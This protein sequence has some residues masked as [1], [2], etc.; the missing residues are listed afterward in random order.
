MKDGYVG[1]VL[2]IW[3][4]TAFV[5]QHCTVLKCDVPLGHGWISESVPSGRW[6]RSVIASM[7][8]HFTSGDTADARIKLLLHILPLGYPFPTSSATVVRQKQQPVNSA[9]GH[10]ANTF[11]LQYFS[12]KFPNAG[13]L[14][15]LGVGPEDDPFR[16]LFHVY[17]KWKVNKIDMLMNARA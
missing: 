9:W 16:L 13:M 10:Q 12:C 4:P 15:V 8:C 7:H 3:V 6:N 11:D 1:N 2:H 14:L 17:F 5:C